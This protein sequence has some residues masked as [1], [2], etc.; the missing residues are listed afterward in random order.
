ML[1]KI[2]VLFTLLVSLFLV[3]GCSSSSTTSTDET[4]DN[5]K[6]EED[7]VGSWELK[8]SYDNGGTDED[9]ISYQ[10]SLVFTFDED[11]KYN[12]KSTTEAMTSDNT[13]AGSSEFTED[14]TWKLEDSQLALTIEKL[15]NLSEEEYK[16]TYPDMFS[17]D[18]DGTELFTTVYYKASVSGNTLTLESDETGSYELTRITE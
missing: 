16:A 6:L 14:G 1:K 7:I 8:D 15:N 9:A 2:T 4:T 11:G 13:E 18:E 17:S 3:A 5:T 10:V 12:I